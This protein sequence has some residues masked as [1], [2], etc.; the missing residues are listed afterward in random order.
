MASAAAAAGSS[1]SADPSA[2]RTAWARNLG[3]PV[4]DFL[5]TE[6][7][8]AAVLVVAA[9]AA[10]VWANS[11][12]PHSYE[13]F[14]STR[15]ALSLGGHVLSGSLRQWVNEGLMALFFL[16]IGLEAKRELDL[17][18]LRERNRIAIPVVAAIGGM[19][20]CVGIYE[21]INAGGAGAGG[22]GAAMSTDTALALGALALVAPSGATR[23]RVFL[24]TLAVVDDLGALVV[25]AVAY[26]GHLSLL[27]LAIALALFAVLALL[28]F[29]GR[30]REPAAVIVG[31]GVWLAMF[32]SGIDPV[33]AGL[34]IGLV[35][36]A[37][38]PERGDLERATELT[39]SFREQPTP[40]L[41]YLAQRGLTSAISPN[42][43]LQYRLHPWTSFVVVPL[44]A[45]A[46]AGIHV[47]AHVLSGAAGS[48][49]TIGIVLAYVL[50]KPLGI[51]GASWLSTRRMV[52][53]ARI[54]LAVT[55]PGLAGT[56]AVAGIGFTVSL[57]IA[58]RAFTGELLAQAKLGVLAAA[59]LSTLAAWIVF[60]LIAR[61]PKTVRARQL[62]RTAA[63]LIDLAEDVDPARDHIRGAPDAPVTLVEYGDFECPYCGRA[64]P[65]IRELLAEWGDDLRYVFR[66]LPLSDV[67]PWAQL[68]AEAAEAAGAQGKFW[69]MYD[70]LLAHQ[71][72]L[73]PGSLRGYA[74]DLGMDVE[75]FAE[76]LRRRTHAARVGEDVASADASGVSGTPSF[77]VNGRRHTGVYDVAT[78]SAA[79]RAARS[80]VPP[81]TAHV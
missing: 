53:G 72:E 77:F 7:G 14:W 23:L 60:R 34:A 41:A 18:E 75:R 11:P 19:A 30:W 17:G 52:G 65:A 31:I 39:R 81:A 21:A 56:A 12:W 43:R 20:L 27:A 79:V 54:K 32:E 22:W 63:Q 46:N 40:E 1:T 80:R 37:Y 42:E 66:H 29:A 36:S 62:G 55:W 59:V 64:E 78:L 74:Q 48:P 9:L 4:R 49:V 16:V 33:V 73:T 71:G 44:F 50:G 67:H 47:D 51:L 6:T 5:S 10:L 8:G 26:S 70:L 68:A 69:E 61:V 28:R 58:D 38:P 2:G 76:E 57:L 35:T 45:L 15:L 13:S 25:I 24:L 3:A